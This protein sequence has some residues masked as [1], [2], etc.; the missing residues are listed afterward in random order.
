MLAFGS[1][2]SRVSTDVSKVVTSV[3]IIKVNSFKF[4]SAFGRFLL[5]PV[6]S[7]S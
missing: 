3:D 2:V 7:S 5:F 6:P 1:S 4:L